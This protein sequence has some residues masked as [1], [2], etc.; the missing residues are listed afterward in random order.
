MIGLRVPPF[1]SRQDL[2]GDLAVLPPLFLH[3]LCDIFC[4]I[5]LLLV[6]VEDGAAVLGSDIWPLPVQSSRIMHLV[7]EFDELAVGDFLGVEDD[8]QGFGIYNRLC[9][10][11]GHH[12]TLEQTYVLF[13]Q[14][15]LLYS[16]GFWCR[17]QCSQ[18]SHL[19]SHDL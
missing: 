6:V 12:N 3:L 2:G 10:Q 4:D 7:E 15:R 1:S 17:R 13:G 14:C 9:Q 19:S 8:L 16:Q 18:P 5:L 11:L